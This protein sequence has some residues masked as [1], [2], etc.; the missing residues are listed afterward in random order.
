MRRAATTGVLHAVRHAA[1]RQ[2]AEPIEC[3]AGA[4]AVAD[5]TL[6]ADIV[7]RLNPHRGMEV[8]AVELGGEG[9]ARPRQVRT[10]APFD[11]GVVNSGCALA[12]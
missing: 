1:V 2:D 3:E 9:S 12:A 4:R 10:T 8:E 11:A 7:A 6:A 5:E